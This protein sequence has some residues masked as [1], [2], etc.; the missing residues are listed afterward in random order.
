MKLFVNGTEKEITLRPWMGTQYGP[1]CFMDLE[2]TYHDGQEITEDQYKELT[3][4]WDSETNDY[5]NGK[6]S[7]GLGDPEEDYT[8][9]Y[10]FCFD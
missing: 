1:D 2:T 3:E 9:E 5:N 10:M 7:D 6:Y 4:W 8:K